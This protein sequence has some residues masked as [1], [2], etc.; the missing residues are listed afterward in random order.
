MDNKRS[1]FKEQT[2]EDQYDERVIEIARVAKVVEGGR[3]FQFRATVVVSDNNGTV[4][5]GVG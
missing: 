3:R 1:R 5:M 2:I 4:G